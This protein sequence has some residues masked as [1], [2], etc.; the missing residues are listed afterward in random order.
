MF[1]GGARFS[2][3][4]KQSPEVVVVVVV[5]VAQSVLP[6]KVLSNKRCSAADT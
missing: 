5:V 3:L 4:S 2:N 1:G 6:I